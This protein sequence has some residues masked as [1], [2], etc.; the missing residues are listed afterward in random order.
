MPLFFIDTSDEQCFIRDEQGHEFDDVEAA[1]VA[2]VDALPDMARDVLP[3]GDT[4]QFL[5][6]VRGS[7]G[8]SLLQASLT[9]HVTSLVPNAQRF[10]YYPPRHGFW[11]STP[12]RKAALA[13]TASFC[14][15][16]RLRFSTRS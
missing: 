16:A 15:R 1:K 8:L 7:D 2:A 5:A 4:R 14:R 12:G 9:L 13:A 3:D 10:G 6:I 11:R